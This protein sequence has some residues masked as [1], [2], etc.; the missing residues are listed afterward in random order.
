M[1]RGAGN[2]ESGL[3]EMR[4]GQID[5]VMIVPLTISISQFRI[6]NSTLRLSSFDLLVRHS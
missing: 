4:K 6:A 2:A 1:N 3:R 5:R